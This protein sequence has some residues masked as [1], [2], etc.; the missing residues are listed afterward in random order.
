MCDSSR[1]LCG[2]SRV[3]YAALV[4]AI[5]EYRAA[6]EANDLDRLV[7][8]LAPDAELV[9]P[10]LAR[11]VIRGK[12]DLRLLFAAVYGSLSELRWTEE[13]VDGDRGF[14]IAQAR[15]G[16]FRID[17]AMVFELDPDGRIQ[18]IRPHLRPWLASTWFALAIG[19]K[20]ARHPG[21]IW[22]AVRRS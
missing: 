1:A 12:N 15:L 9:S 8:T 16:L 6:S 21:V 2:S 4:D 5:A 14:M 19:V 20:M 7:D 17:D 13:I 10:L 11:G 3:A 18:R 22:R